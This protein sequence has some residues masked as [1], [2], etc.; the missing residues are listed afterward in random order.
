MQKL[1]IVLKPEKTF[2]DMEKIS[3]K[4]RFTGRCVNNSLPMIPL[5]PLDLKEARRPHGKKERAGWSGA[6]AELEFDGG[7]S[8]YLDSVQIIRKTEAV[9]ANTEARFEIND[10]EIVIPIMTTSK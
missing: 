5:V 8:D 6:R 3:G 1:K 9:V 2:L 10:N 4:I 7:K